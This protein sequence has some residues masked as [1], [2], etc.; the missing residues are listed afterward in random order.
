M[1]TKPLLTFDSARTYVA[2]YFDKNTFFG[3][4]ITIS[5]ADWNE[6]YGEGELI[7]VNFTFAS[8]PGKTYSMAVWYDGDNLYGEW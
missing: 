2:E 4:P 5:G 3:D 6:E 7:E 1:T 8:E